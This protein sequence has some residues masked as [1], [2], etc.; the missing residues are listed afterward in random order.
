MKKIMIVGGLGSSLLR[1]RGELIKSWLEKG[2]RVTAA[3]PDRDAEDELIGLGVSYYTVPINRTGM[4][5]LHDFILWIKMIGLLKK[6]QPDYLFL[7]T[8]KPVIY[9]SLAALFWQRIKVFSMITGLG[10]ALSAAGSAKLQ[11]LVLF[12][13][14]LALKNNEKVFFQNPDDE[15]LFKAKKMVRKNQVVRVNGSGVDLKYFSPE[16]SPEGPM[17]FL[18]IARLL[19]EKGVREYV[20]AARVLKAKYPESQ[21]VLLGWAFKENPSAISKGEVEEWQKE[22]VVELFS[23]SDD[24]RPFIA[25]SSVY[26]LPSYREGTP[27]T[28]LEAMAMGRPVVTTAAA[29]CRE[30]VKEGFNGFLV[31]VKDALALSEAMEKF[32][33]EPGLVQKMGKTSRKLAEEKYDVHMVNRVINDNMGIL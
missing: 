22:G 5:P 23:E 12:L 32:I 26:V 24:V 8:V 18:M 30:T 3:A 7:Y 20:E 21:F 10:Y 28:V 4:N 11:K 16:P 25:R 27:R 9:G 15:A 19:V 14:R 29:G 31:P 13:Y 1:F 2:Y 33:L 6:E 17:R